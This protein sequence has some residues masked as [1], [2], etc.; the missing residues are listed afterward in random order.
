[1]KSPSSCAQLGSAQLDCARLALPRNARKSVL[2][3][4]KIH[5]ILS[6]TC[7]GSKILAG[8]CDSRI[9]GQTTRRN[10]FTM[11]DRVFDR[12][13]AHPLPGWPREVARKLRRGESP[14]RTNISEFR[15]NE[16]GAAVTTALTLAV[17]LAASSSARSAVR[18][19]RIAA[20]T[21]PCP[22]GCWTSCRYRRSLPTLSR[23][24]LQTCLPAEL[25]HVSNYRLWTLTVDS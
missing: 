13:H 19:E 8:S 11:A 16:I 14:T 7:P 1:M 15:Q 20:T 22:S 21:P 18:A 6:W 17:Q 4:A 10:V 23:M 25:P 12:N 3:I 5:C 9:V 2:H 24:L